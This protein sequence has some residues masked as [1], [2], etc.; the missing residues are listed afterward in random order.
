VD[1]YSRHEQKKQDLQ[2]SNKRRVGSKGEDEAKTEARGW[3]GRK[4]S[5][6]HVYICAY[7]SH[8]RY[9]R[10]TL[11]CVQVINKPCVRRTGSMRLI[12]WTHRRGSEQLKTLY[13]SPF[14][15]LFGFLGLISI[16]CMVLKVF[17]LQR[18]VF[19]LK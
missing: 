14:R 16:I 4:S 17:A 18:I 9:L 11:F 8:K 13:F 2:V 3:V 7:L 1:G 19:A 15:G 6:L 12:F 10:I 5:S